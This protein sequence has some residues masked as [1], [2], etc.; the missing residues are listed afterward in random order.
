MDNPLNKSGKDDINIIRSNG[1]KIILNKS[2]I[3]IYKMLYLFFFLFFTVFF[4]IVIIS[5][6]KTIK[7]YE[8]DNKLLLDNKNQ[9]KT[10]TS[11]YEEEMESNEKLYNSY[12]ETIKELKNK[13]ITLQEKL[14]D[15]R[16]DY[17]D[18]KYSVERVFQLNRGFQ[19]TLDE[20]IEENNK[21]YNEIL[22]YRQSNFGLEIEIKDLEYKIKE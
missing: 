17:E 1:K 11:N 9:V 21:V 13:N 5:T 19:I 4:L 16:D 12:T 18:L 6:T 15:L 2:K 10:G 20:K 7:E 3:G 22:K 14:N 8:N